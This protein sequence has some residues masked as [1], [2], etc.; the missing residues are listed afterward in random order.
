MCIYIKFEINLIAV[1]IATKILDD[2]NILKY[3]KNFYIQ[4]QK[5]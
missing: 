4:F 1:K 3:N 5:I 2:E